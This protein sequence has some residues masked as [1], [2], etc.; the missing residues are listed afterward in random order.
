MVN[1]NST[2]VLTDI[3]CH[4][5]A[6]YRWWYVKTGMIIEIDNFSGYRTMMCFCCAEIYILLYICLRNIPQ[7]LHHNSNFYSLANTQFFRCFYFHK[8]VMKYIFRYSSRKAFFLLTLRNLCMKY[9][10]YT[11]ERVECKTTSNISDHKISFKTFKFILIF[12]FPVWEIRIRRW[13]TWVYQFCGSWCCTYV[14]IS[15]NSISCS[16]K[17]INSSSI[18]V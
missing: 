1:F 8:D 12:D 14:S 4:I 18:A 10:I 11:F 3:E 9:T 17:N 13:F 7:W 5:I 6:G 2:T 15:E 16:Q